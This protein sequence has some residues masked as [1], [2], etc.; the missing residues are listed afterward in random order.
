MLDVDDVVYVDDVAD[1][2]AISTGSGGLVDLLAVWITAH[3]SSANST[4]PASPAAM[5][6][7][8]WSCQLPS[9]SSDTGSPT[10]QNLLGTSGKS[11]LEERTEADAGDTQWAERR[12]V[13]LVGQGNRVDG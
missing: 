5:M 11:A 1:D 4:N 8:C 10:V 3:T 6:T 9:S 7:C 2:G 13:G 12:G